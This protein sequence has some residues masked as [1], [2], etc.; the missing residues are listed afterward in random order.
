MHSLVFYGLWWIKA[1]TVHCSQSIYTCTDMQLFTCSSYNTPLSISAHPSLDK[2]VCCKSP[3][4]TEIIYIPSQ[5]SPQLPPHGACLFV[6]LK[7][8]SASFTEARPLHL[9]KKDTILM[10]FRQQ[11]TF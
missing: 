8:I 4:V 6:S 11:Q 9:T 3:T 1:V 5:L 7:I 10:A 2:P